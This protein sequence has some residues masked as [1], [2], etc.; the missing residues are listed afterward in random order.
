MAADS[1]FSSAVTERFL[2]YARVDTQSDRSSDAVPS[3]PGQQDLLDMLHRELKELGVEDIELIEGAYLIARISESDPS[4]ADVRTIGFM[5]HVDTAS[6]VSG[7]GV[8]PQVIRNYDGSDVSLGKSGL[9]LSP[10]D[11]KPLAGCIGK[12]IITT[13]GT[14]LLGA[15]DKAGVAEIMTA[16][17]HLLHTPGME[18]GPIEVV[19]TTDEETGRGMDRFPADRLNSVFCCTLD[20][21]GRGSVE[22]ECFHALKA[23][24]TCRGISYHLGDARGRMVNALAMAGAFL[25]MIPRTESPE[26]TDGRYGYYCPLH[27]DGDVETASIEVFIRDFDREEALRRVQVLEQIGQAVEAAFPGGSVKV[28]SQWQ[29]ENMLEGIS[30]DERILEVIQD[31]L[32]RIN[33]PVKR[34]IIRGGTDG[35]RLTALGIPTPNIF[36]GGYNF[37]SRYEWA[38]IDYMAEASQAVEQIILLWRERST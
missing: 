32:S 9:T 28:D 16:M 22:A 30:R 21:S 27:M 12:D 35:A 17:E 2:G 5:A 13:D 8:N 37:H 24:V 38:C 19:F 20:G 23:D 33:I 26:A 10:R 3:T 11:H 36:T 25:T 14:T 6:D 15:D 29:Y 31:A 1:W 7:R 18:H 34:T 4:L